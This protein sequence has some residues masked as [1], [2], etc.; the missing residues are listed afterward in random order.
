MLSM[1]SG[2][3]DG[4]RSLWRC[5][6]AAAKAKPGGDFQHHAVHLLL[7]LEARGIWIDGDHLLNL[8]DGRTSV[9]PG[10][11]GFVTLTEP[12]SQCDAAILPGSQVARRGH[13]EAQ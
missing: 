11:S 7:G 4:K 8:F 1:L 6:G 3:C 13:R 5:Y 9:R 2:S 10:R 12:V